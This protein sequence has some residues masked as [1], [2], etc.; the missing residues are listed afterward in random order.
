MKKDQLKIIN[1]CFKREWWR[2]K[3]GSKMQKKIN[4][5]NVFYLNQVIL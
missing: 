3:S 1:D 5:H 2:E 4:Y